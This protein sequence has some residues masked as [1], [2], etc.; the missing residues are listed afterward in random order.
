LYPEN[1]G[2]IGN[3]IYDNASDS[4]FNMI[5]APGADNVRWWNDAEPVWITAE[6]NNKRSALYWWA[7]CEVE[8]MGGHPTI[9]E[10]QFYDG[11]P[12]KEMATDYLER[13]DD[14]IQM[15]KPSKV[16]GDRLSLVLM[17]YVSVDYNGHHFGPQSPELKT[18]LKDIDEILDKMQQ[19]IKD[20]HLEDEVNL[21][22]I[23]DHGMTDVRENVVRHL[24][25][26]KY[27][28]KIKYH[29]GSGPILRIQPQ[30]GMLNKLLQDM[31][32]DKIDGVRI[33]KKEDIPEKYH[34]KGS[35]KMEP[36]IL[37]A[38]KG[39]YI[40]PLDDPKTP[41][42]GH[43][44]YDPEDVEDMRTIFLAT[45]PDFRKGFKTDILYN[46]DIYNIMCTVLGIP[47]LPNNGSWERVQSMLAKTK[48]RPG[49]TDKQSAATF[50]ANGYSF[51]LVLLITICSTMFS[52]INSRFL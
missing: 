28:P 51:S 34:L 41:L 10:R 15:F 31:T 32:A 14:V 36:L 22:I 27:A 47:A 45:G 37:V 25:L 20:A 13:I 49:T 4:Y 17:Y 35:N 23:S 19:K 21:M 26:R 7:G 16:L 12:I 24:D 38:K 3:I 8:I 42:A 9:C 6:K 1:H 39:Y 43:H 48:D 18:A 29:I 11:P 40:D 33:Y 30:P 44:G 52:M 46:T 50:T 5:P 2:F